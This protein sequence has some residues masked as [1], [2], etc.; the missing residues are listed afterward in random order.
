MS[1]FL[2]FSYVFTLLCLL[3]GAPFLLYKVARRARGSALSIAHGVMLGI[4]VDVVVLLPVGA[5]LLFSGGLGVPSV[6]GLPL[7]A[8]EGALSAAVIEGIRAVLLAHVSTRVRSARAAV[9]FGLGW[10]CGIAWFKG[11]SL[12][13][14]LRGFLYE[15]LRQGMDLLSGAGQEVARSLLEQQRAYLL[16][17]SP[18]RPP[19]EHVLQYGFDA[20]FHLA[21]TIMIVRTWTHGERGAWLRAAGLHAALAGSTRLVFG[22]WPGWGGLLAALVLQA[23]LV[24]PTWRWMARQ[25]V[26]PEP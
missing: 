10:G 3:L 24:G 26:R 20:F 5:A 6:A 19:L 25:I 16:E 23:S 18:L 15:D 12:L 17:A 4:G 1:R 21:F 11:L 9:H 22:S 13:I 2:A 7:L 8:L 14:A